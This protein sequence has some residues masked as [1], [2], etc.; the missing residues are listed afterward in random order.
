[1]RLTAIVCACL[2]LGGA[3]TGCDRQTGGTSVPK[4]KPASEHLVEVQPVVLEPVSSAYQRT[5]SLKAR[6]IARVY[7]QEEG[8]IL[9][10]PWYEG[11]RVEKNALLLRLDDALLRAELDKAWATARQANLNLE[12]LDNLVKRNAVSKDERERARTALDVAMAERRMLETRLS[13]MRV[14]A[15]FTGLVSARLAEPGDVIGEHTHV[16]TL[17]DPSS[18]VIEVQVSE[19][20]LPH[21]K[22][23]NLVEIRI[24]ALGRV[25]YSGK[26]LRIHPALDPSTRQGVVEVALDPV[27]EG[28]RAGQFARVTLKTAV[29]P[30]LLIPFPA[31]QRDRQGEYV[32]LVDADSKA[33]RTLVRSGLRAAQRVEILEGLSPG[34]Q[35]IT[36]GLLGLADGKKVKAVA[37]DD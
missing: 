10:L 36:R 14:E 17:I 12:R 25:E 11:D 8:R 22:L 5:A 35:V 13:Y 20:L 21:L 18:L 26:I 24:D 30:R 1:M 4:Q 31:L 3:L 28:A 37:S 9:D 6:R 2:L 7:N 29:A 23:G 19:L 34:Q 27:P 33:R 16:L 15:P 32:Y